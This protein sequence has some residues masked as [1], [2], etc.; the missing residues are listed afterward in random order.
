MTQAEIKALTVK[1]TYDGT[2]RDIA[3]ALLRRK[4]G[5]PNSGEYLR[6]ISNFIRD[7][8]TTQLPP[9]SQNYKWRLELEFKDCRVFLNGEIKE[10]E[11]SADD[12]G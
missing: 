4:K 5:V 3:L 11:A 10:K 6:L 1:D 2:V 8:Y 12:A 7:L 9:R